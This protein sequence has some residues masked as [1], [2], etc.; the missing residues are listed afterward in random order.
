MSW[1]EKREYRADVDAALKNIRSSVPATG[2]STAMLP[3]K[4]K[5]VSD[6]I[7]VFEL[8]EL[9]SYGTLS[10]NWICPFSGVGFSSSLVVGRRT[11]VTGTSLNFEIL[12]V[13]SWSAGVRL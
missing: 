3:P 1:D 10:G 11:F 4:V 7:L 8:K 5:I 12:S 6:L 13:L 2:A 9:E